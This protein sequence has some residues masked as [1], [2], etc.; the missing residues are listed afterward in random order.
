MKLYFNTTNDSNNRTIRPNVSASM[1]S[2]KNRLADKEELIERI[3]SSMEPKKDPN[4]PNLDNTKLR[5]GPSTWYLFHTLSE[6]IK[7][8][9]FMNIRDEFLDIVKS[10][11]INLPCP[12]CAEHATN[13]IKNLNYNSIQSKDDLKL[14]FLNFHNFVNQRNKKPSFSMIE[15]ND[16]YSKAKTINVMKNFISVFQYKNKGFNMIANEMQRQ[17]QVE[18]YKDWFNKNYLLFYE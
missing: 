4:P 18:I 13:Y 3:K 10:I 16:K 5:W 8:E 15:L 12:S 17:R 6:K 11:C 1:I 2:F 9:H 7:P 14:F